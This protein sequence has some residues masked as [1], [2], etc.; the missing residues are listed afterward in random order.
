MTLR[1]QKFQDLDTALEREADSQALCYNS[2]DF[3]KGLEAVAR[4]GK[5]EFEGW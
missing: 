3:L 2:M 5:A 4:R 1:H